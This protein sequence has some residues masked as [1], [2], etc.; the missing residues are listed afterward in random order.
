MRADSRV[1]QLRAERE[2]L[3]ALVEVIAARGVSALERG[4]VA[5]FEQAAN[6]TDRLRVVIDQVAS[7]TDA[8]AHAWAHRLL[9]S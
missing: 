2:L 5:D 7:L 6:D 4:F 3:L 8:S 1:G 9:G